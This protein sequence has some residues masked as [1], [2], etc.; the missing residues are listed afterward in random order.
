MAGGGPSLTIGVGVAS[1]TGARR[2]NE[3]FVGAARPSPL[4]AD[5]FGHALALADGMGGA[6]GGREAAETAVRG[7]LDGYYDK[8]E[9]WGTRRTASS[10]LEAL[11]GWIHAIGRQGELAGMGCTFTGLVLRGRTA[12]VLH[13]GDSR[14]YRFG[15]GRLCRLT[16]DH[17]MD[18]PGLT[19][20]LYR[21]MGLEEGLRLDYASHPLDLHDRFLICSDGVHGALSNVRIADILARQQG[22]EETA[23][24]LV[25][26]AIE[27]DSQDN[28]SALVVDIL[29]LPPADRAGLRQALDGLPIPPLPRSGET[30]DG[31]LLG[32]LLSDGR[33]TRL[34][35]A[36]DQ[37]EGGAVV[38]KFPRPRAAG[39]DAFKSAFLREALVSAEIRSPHVGHVI[40]LPP[41]RQSRLYAVMPFYE[42]ETLEQRLSRHPKLGLEEGRRIGV[43]LCQAVASLHRAGVIHRDIK[44]DN[45]ILGA[46]G[47]VRLIDLGVVRLPGL[48]EIAGGDIP[49]TPSFM[50]PELF[51]G[52]RGDEASDI[53]AL[54]ATL[55]RAFTGHFPHGEIEPFTKPRFGKARNLNKD[56]PDLPSWLDFTLSKAMAGLPRER[57]AD[58]T[59][60]LHALESGPSA[61]PADASRRRPLYQRNP[62]LF[63]QI[64]AALQGLLLAWC[65]A[66]R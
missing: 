25:T 41:D 11:N 19:H 2:R 54:G 33:Y 15:Q 13:V 31:F 12:H 32:K 59:E 30:V 1:E 58:A 8:P 22:P 23:R 24:A 6:K 35:V 48:E 14:L 66:R 49:G 52:E 50:A 46:G 47:E 27:A 44:P 17:C 39:D 55:Y 65:L 56:R 18:Q 28:A 42:G 60:M 64:I 3:D 53:Y 63:W 36:E 43:K 34:F 62:L 37:Q 38:L 21:A 7:F 26:A 40:E 5:R 9:S 45:V 16:Q 57:F 29:A 10:V 20:V 4:S 51:E 61:R